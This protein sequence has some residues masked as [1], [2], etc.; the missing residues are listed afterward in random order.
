M[1]S[2]TTTTIVIYNYNNRRARRNIKIERTFPEILHGHISN[3]EW[4]TFCNKVDDIVLPLE[5][6]RKNHY[7]RMTTIGVLFVIV[8]GVSVY[9]TDQEIGGPIVEAVVG[10]IFVVVFLLFPWSFIRFR[11][12]CKELEEELIRVLNSESAR[13]NTNSNVS[14]SLYENP[15]YVGKTIRCKVTSVSVDNPFITTVP[16]KVSTFDSL[17]SETGLGTNASSVNK[18]VSTFDSLAIE[19]GLNLD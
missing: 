16:K 11:N 14:F 17:H 4:E 6:Y 1:S 5:A 13:E 9:V 18:N 8:C 12:Q 2:T 15:L 7:F 10:G 3:S 19:T